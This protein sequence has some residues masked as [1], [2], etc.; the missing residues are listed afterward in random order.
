MSS[1]R[2]VIR[3][4]AAAPRGFDALTVLVTLG[5]VASP[6]TGVKVIGLPASDVA[7]VLAAVVLFVKV[8]TGDR[9]VS[10]RLWSFAPVI[11]SFVIVAIDVFSNRAALSTSFGATGNIEGDAVFLG[12]GGA[13]LFL[14]RTAIATTLVFM[15]VDAETRRWGRVAPVRALTA[16]VVGTLVS[17]AVAGAR[18]LTGLTILEQ[19]V[20]TVGDRSAGLAFHPNSLGQSVALAIPAL[21]LAAS[22]HRAR[23]V[24]TLAVAGAYVLLTWGLL[25]A[26]SRGALIVSGLVGI[27]VVLAALSRWRQGRWVV[28]AGIA[29]GLVSMY[30]VPAL[31][32]GTRLAAGGPL[33]IADEDVG[34]EQLLAQ[35]WDAFSSSPFVG[36]GLDA[37]SG[38][39]VA[40]FLASSG[41]I[42]LLA[43][44]TIFVA[45]AFALQWTRESPL[46]RSYGSIAILALVLM[47]LPNNSVNE[48]F[49]YI[50]VAA[51]AACALNL[52]AARDR[53]TRRSRFSSRRRREP[54]AFA[55]PAFL[56]PFAASGAG[57][58][59]TPRTARAT[60][61]TP[62]RA[63]G[64]DLPP[65]EQASGHRRRRR[66][67]R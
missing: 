22:Q 21:A 67:T 45:R 41:G 27:M 63:D 8:M 11:A 53:R 16:F 40:A 26:D 38:V 30:A 43:G 25:L 28:P 19:S 5:I 20:T 18:D 64:T 1:S 57:A 17:V 32:S 50:A 29:V 24:R 54:P 35:A 51:V 7:F 39:M 14:L 48:R 59:R 23:P 42:V 36:V 2:E 49:D 13:V 9:A 31:I 66:P 62:L 3:E 52:G 4:D 6:W 56:A 10:L 33:G 15:L 58:E 44:F 37:G 60:T 47:G 61:R 12:Q 65:A 55:S 46:P 34:R